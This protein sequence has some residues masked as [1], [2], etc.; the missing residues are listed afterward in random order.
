MANYSTV[1]GY[2]F[3]AQ[4]NYGWGLTL[5]MTGKAP[6]VSKRIFD[7]YEHMLYYVNDYNDSCVPGLVLK[8]MGDTDA[9]KNGVYFVAKIGTN[10]PE[11][12]ENGEVVLDDKG[13][14][15]LTNTFA[16]DGEVIKLAS[17]GKVSGDVSVLQEALEAEIA[18]RK[19]VDGQTGQTYVANS[20][21]TYISGASSLNDADA[22]LDV[23]ISNEVSAREQAIEDI[24]GDVSETDAKTI[25]GLND[26]IDEVSANYLT[27]INVN[28]IAGTVASNIASV[29][30]EGDNVVVSTEYGD[31]VVYPEIS[32]TAVVF[33]SVS[34]N[35]KVSAAIKK[36]DQNISTLVQEVLKD[37]EVNAAA[38]TEIKQSVGLSENLKYVKNTEATYISGAETL[39]EADSLL[40]AAIKAEVSARQ[41]ADKNLQKAIDAVSNAAISVA[42]GNG[43]SVSGDGTE[44]TIAA[45]A[46]GDD[47]LITVTDK[48]IGIKDNGYI[49]C[50]TF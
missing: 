21:T 18:A 39:S 48:G 19:A 11:A 35:D 6:E 9:L 42:A 34:G 29:T 43:I 17:E 13:K 22:K 44:K 7:T 1:D 5:N 25:A 41:E 16:N 26:K 8:V 33:N 40:D 30:I 36:L 28:G 38:I 4:I 3:D 45:V 10:K 2:K 12:N 23:A 46:N 14:P 50:G 20:N 31:S 27:N 15:V 32:D 37:E 24:L 47:S 49:D